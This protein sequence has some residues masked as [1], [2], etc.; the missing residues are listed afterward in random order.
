V[1]NLFWPP[2]TI[3]A[4][5][6]EFTQL[7]NNEWGQA[8]NS[9]YAPRNFFDDPIGFGCLHDIWSNF[10]ILLEFP[11]ALW[12]RLNN[13]IG[14]LMGYIAIIIILVEAILGAIAGSAAGGVGAIPGALIGAKAGLATVAALGEALMF[15]FIAAEGISVQVIIARLFTARQTCEKRQRDILNSVSSFIA[16]GVAITLQ[17]LMALLSSLVSMI[18]NA[19]KGAPKGIPKA[20]PVEAPPPIEAP[21]P[22]GGDVIPFPSR[23]A[24]VQSPP[25]PE[26]IAA[27]FEDSRS[28]V[29]L[30]ETLKEEDQSAVSQADGSGGNTKANPDLQTVSLLGV[31]VTANPAHQ[32]ALQEDIDPDKC[33]EEECTKI[34]VPPNI[35]RWGGVYRNPTADASILGLMTN[36]RESEGYQ[37]EQDYFGNNIAG[38]K[39]IIFSDNSLMHVVREGQEVS[40]NDELHSEQRI[41]SRLEEIIMGEKP[42]HVL[43]VDQIVSER[44]P[45]SGCYDLIRNNPS[46]KVLTKRSDVFYF[47]KY[48]RNRITMARDLKHQYCDK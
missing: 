9:L 14:L 33:K 6:R 44:S 19:I 23:P 4:I 27:K 28:Y 20:P 3:K 38:F 42:K 15:S 16:M 26:K 46:T 48:I 12:R 24:P 32:V 21:V 10:L 18:A 11:L 5:F 40:T 43:F 31:P 34:R 25:V 7:W 36:Q 37:Q 17:V 8:L 30:P 45:C 47:T 41:I 22:A 39:Y 2:A 35:K 13:V 29:S 1:V